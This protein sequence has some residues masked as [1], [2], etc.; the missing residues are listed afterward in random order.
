MNKITGNRHNELFCHERGAIIQAAR[1]AHTETISGICPLHGTHTVK[2]PWTLIAAHLFDLLD[3]IDTLGDELKDGPDDL[4]RARALEIAHKRFK[5][6]DTDG[7]D[8][9]FKLP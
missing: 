3:D 4:F 8:L 9:R 6:A 7:Y 2:Q 5:V 1:D